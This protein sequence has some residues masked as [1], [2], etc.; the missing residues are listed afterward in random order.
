MVF[1]SGVIFGSNFQKEVSTFF[2][3]IRSA[4]YGVIGLNTWWVFTSSAGR[5]R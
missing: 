2:G 3:S 1:I 5:R 4:L